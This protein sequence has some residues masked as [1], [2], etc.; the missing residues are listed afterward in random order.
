MFPVKTLYLLY[1]PFLGQVCQF[2][3]AWGESQAGPWN[4]DAGVLLDWKCLN[5]LNLDDL[6]KASQGP[7][8][9]QIPL[10]FST[11]SIINSPCRPFLPKQVKEPTEKEAKAKARARA[12]AKAKTSAA[13]S[14]PKQ[15]HSSP[16]GGNG[17]K[18]K[19][20]K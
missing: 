2:A 13:K 20:A 3:C 4:D 14:K 11:P 7:I 5:P 18:R 1:P 16:K 19:G 17:N 6:L 10:N 15:E 8:A 12:K 9:F